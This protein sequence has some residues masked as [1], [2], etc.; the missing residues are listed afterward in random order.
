MRERPFVFVLM[1]F[2][3]EFT[4]VYTELIKDPLEEIG[5][6]VER[7]DSL[8]N[9][10]QILKDVV[11]GIANAELV[12]ADVTGLNGNVLYELGLAH[13]L[14][15][16]TIMI[17]QSLD[18]LPFDLRAYRA[19]EYSTLFNRAQE[20]KQLL[21]DVGNAVLQDQADF[22]NP[23]QDFAPDALQV[24]A[25]VS[26]SR[27]GGESSTQPAVQPETAEDVEPPG[28]LELLVGMERGGATTAALAERISGLTEDVG[29]RI[30][31]H[32]ERLTKAK[33][34][35]GDRAAG[36]TLA[37]ARDAAHDID[38][39]ANSLE[40]LIGDFR[41]SLADVVAGAN[42]LAREGLVEGDEDVKSLEEMIKS[43]EGA[44]R[45]MESGREGVLSFAQSMLE[46]PNMER[47]LTRAAKRAAEVV[48][49]VAKE[50]ETGESEFARVRGLLQERV[51]AYR[52]RSTS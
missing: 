17:T 6:Q 14:G 9:Q 41:T 45:G 30:S 7:A 12:V 52:L 34:N 47:T 44:E 15:K 8:F 33:E 40:P 39:Y 42:A 18:E 3:A 13:A 27:P 25:Q 49:A 43:I 26:V 11:K 21:K 32:T 48:L 38:E 23:V 28:V 22:S 4:D 20:L 50:I 16:R 1:P 24:G 2:D 35:L 19:N 36:A 31:Q 29:T 10:Q 37:I 46:M 51:D 5:F